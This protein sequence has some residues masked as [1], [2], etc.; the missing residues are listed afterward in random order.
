MP[1]N[2]F[3]IIYIKIN[4]FNNKLKT[5][6]IS[7]ARHGKLKIIMIKICLIKISSKGLQYNHMYNMLWMVDGHFNNKTN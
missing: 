3:I 2:Y 1:I 5:M 4:V 7:T 6:I